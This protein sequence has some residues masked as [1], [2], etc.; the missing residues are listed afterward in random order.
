M[1]ILN[2][3]VLTCELMLDTVLLDWYHVQFLLCN[4]VMQLYLVTELPCTAACVTNTAHSIN[5]HGCCIHFP[6]LWLSFINCF[7][8]HSRIYLKLLAKLQYCHLCYYKLFSVCLF[9]YFTTYAQLHIVIC[10]AGKL[11]DKSY[12][13]KLQCYHRQRKGS[14]V[15]GH[16]GEC[17]ARAYNGGLGAESP[18]EAESILVIG[19]PTEPANLARFRYK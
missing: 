3:T 5:K 2:H 12:V 7:L 16:H 9:M 11:H 18:P 10:P 4:L 13:V 19:C 15:G 8:I 6:R 14:V 1:I 17:G